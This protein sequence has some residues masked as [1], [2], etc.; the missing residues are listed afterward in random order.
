MSANLTYTKPADIDG[1]P[2]D[3][4]ELSLQQLGEAL[5]QVAELTELTALQLRAEGIGR[6]GEE[7]GS[8]EEAAAVGALIFRQQQQLERLRW[9]QG[10]V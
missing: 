2:A 6:L 8:S 3:V 1:E 9:L 5:A 7:W 10:A 4:R